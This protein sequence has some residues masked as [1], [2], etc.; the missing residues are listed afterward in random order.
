[1]VARH[2]AAREAVREHELLADVHS[3]LRVSWASR[4]CS[5]G[6]PSSSGFRHAEY[7]SHEAL[8]QRDRLLGGLQFAIDRRLALARVPAR[9]LRVQMRDEIAQ[10]LGDGRALRAGNAPPPATSTAPAPFRRRGRRSASG[11][12]CT[13]RFAVST[14]ANASARDVA[15]SGGLWRAGRPGE[16][17]SV[18]A[19]AQS[20]SGAPGIAGEIARERRDEIVRHQVWRRITLW[21]APDRLRKW[22]SSA[23]RCRSN[24][25]RALLAAAQHRSP[26]PSNE[27]AL[28][29]AAAGP[30]HVIGQP[31][32]PEE[33]P[34][35][36]RPRC[37]RP[38]STRVV[39]EAREPCRHDGHEVR[40]FDRSR[41]SRRRAAHSRAHCISSS[42]RKRTCVE[43]SGRVVASVP[44]SPQQR[45]FSRHRHRPSSR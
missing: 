12:A 10:H 17:G 25:R 4:P 34:S 9:E 30:G 39:V 37:S 44:D 36:F 41:G 27:N 26:P 13:Q 29:A 6:S 35:R 1:M 31:I 21:R 8:P 24:P 20:A 5:S 22:V 16:I 19:S 18:I 23:K 3:A 14:S 7:C 43:T 32:R 15:L 45:S 40:T 38:S 11:S 28:D 42:L 2:G 33:M